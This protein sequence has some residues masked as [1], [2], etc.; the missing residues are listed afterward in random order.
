MSFIC[1]SSLQLIEKIGYTPAARQFLAGGNRQFPYKLSFSRSDVISFRSEHIEYMSISGVQDKISLKLDRGG[2]LQPVEK[3]GEYILKPIPSITLPALLNDVPAN[4]HLT[5][6]IAKQLFSISIPPNACVQ[7][8]DG[9][10]AYLVKRFDRHS[11]GTKTAQEDFCQ[12]SGR[13]SESSNNYKYEGSYEE[14]GKLLKKYCGAYTIE[15]EKLF[16]LICFNYIFSNG[17]AH[18]K[19]FSLT[20]TSNGD[21]ILTPGYDL[22]CTSM[23][24][25]N[26]AQ[27]ALDLFDD[28]YETEYYKTNAFYGRPDFIELAYRFGIAN[29]RAEL[30]L[31]RFAIEKQTV[32]KLINNSFLS[33]EAKQNYTVR[34]YDRLRT[35]Q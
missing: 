8:K 16:K 9:E 31:N 28:D 4:E 11:D 10:P 29:H 20:Q 23:H 7:L 2:I 14:L 12:L 27:M 22:L 17:D 6:Q 35:M 26:E 21:Y 1:R 3:N 24:L 19:N 25:P 5:M 18:L 32:I 33:P 34:F 15:V 13:S 30:I